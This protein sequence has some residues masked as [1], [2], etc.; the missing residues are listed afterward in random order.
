MLSNALVDWKCLGYEIVEFSE[1]GK[2]KKASIYEYKRIKLGELIQ[3][4]K[5]CLQDFI[6]CNYIAAW[7]DLQFKELFASVSHDSI[8]SCLDFSEYYTMMVQNEI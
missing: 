1:D 6:V 4:L 3:H 2:P 5:S 8:I 7:Q